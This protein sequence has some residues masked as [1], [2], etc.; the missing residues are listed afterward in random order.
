LKELSER[1]YE[2]LIDGIRDGIVWTADP[3]SLRVAYISRRAGELTG[4]PAKEWASRPGLLRERIHPDDREK[5]IETFTR[6]RSTRETAALEYR[7]V[8][9]DG[10][11]IWFHTEA[12]L[13]PGMD[14]ERLELRGLSV[15]VTHLKETE[16]VLRDTVRLREEFLAIASHELRTPITP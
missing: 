10:E 8:R 9:A 11:V 14:S 4:F 7:F 1:R 12:H 15:D 13:E 2:K 5:A 6:L 16:Q 3:E